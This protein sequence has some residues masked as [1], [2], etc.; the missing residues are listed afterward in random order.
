MMRM[1]MNMVSKMFAPDKPSTGAA[2]PGP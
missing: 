2:P 1:G